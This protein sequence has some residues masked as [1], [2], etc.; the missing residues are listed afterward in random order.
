MKRASE[1]FITYGW[2]RPRFARL[3][4]NPLPT[5][6]PT[7]MKTIGTDG[8]ASRIAE[9]PAALSTRIASGEKLEISA[10]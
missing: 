3:F 6:S 2:P 8:A 9:S 10:T 4:T 7:M 1:T 5:G